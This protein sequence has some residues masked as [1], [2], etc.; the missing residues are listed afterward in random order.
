[1]PSVFAQISPTQSVS[2]S[3][4]IHQSS[5]DRKM[6]RI[7]GYLDSGNINIPQDVIH[8]LEEILLKM[9]E[10]EYDGSLKRGVIHRAWRDKHSLYDVDSSS[11]I[12]YERY[13]RKLR[14]EKKDYFA[15]YNYQE[16]KGQRL[17]LREQALTLL[18][19]YLKSII[20][21]KPQT[22]NY[23]DI[24]DISHLT[25]EEH[26]KYKV[27]N[28]RKWMDRLGYSLSKEEL[29]RL[30][31]PIKELLPLGKRGKVL[32]H[33]K[34]PSDSPEMVKHKEKV[35]NARK[36]IWDI[37]NPYIKAYH[38]QKDAYS[39]KQ[40]ILRIIIPIHAPGDLVSPE[41]IL[42]RDF[43]GLV[44]RYTRFGIVISANDQLDI[45]NS[46]KEKSEILEEI[47]IN[48]VGAGLEYDPNSI[49]VFN[50]NSSLSK[51]ENRLQDSLK[52][53]DSALESARKS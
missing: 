35:R 18:D 15:S 37:I 4:S 20:A 47:K 38:A 53:Y 51:I 30:E 48:R 2:S 14:Q 3:S 19:T 10:V 32:T 41:E 22:Y 25:K 52:P 31:E 7:Q 46:M 6:K 40:N 13:I 43:D 11:R 28:Y 24:V 27:E 36:P 23:S 50:L 29:R 21:P 17:K 12:E 42:D 5:V 8:Q 44:K 9:S 45:K 33:N 1:M 16:L 39:A 26:V 34:I 49:E